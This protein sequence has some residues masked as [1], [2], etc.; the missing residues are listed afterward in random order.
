LWPAPPGAL[1]VAAC[2]FGAAA[3][4]YLG[5]RGEV[6]VPFDPSEVSL[7]SVTARGESGVPISPDA[8]PTVRH[9][10]GWGVSQN[11]P[12]LPFKLPH[13][14]YRFE[15]SCYPGRTVD[16][17][18]ITT[19]GLFSSRTD[20]NYE[21]APEI[22]LGRGDRVTVRAVMRNVPSVPS[23]PLPKPDDGWVK[24]FHG[25]DLTGWKTHPEQPGTWRA[26]GKLLVADGD[27]PGHLFSVRDDYK[28][29][30]FR[31]EA[32]VGDQVR[33]AQIVRASFDL[34]HKWEMPPDSYRAPKGLLAPLT[35][36]ALDFNRVGWLWGFPE[37]MRT[38]PQGGGTRWESSSILVNSDHWFTQE[39]VARGPSISLFIDGKHR[40]TYTD[41]SGAARKGH[42]SLG[43]Y[44]GK[45][46]IRK[47]EVKELPPEPAAG[48]GTK[49]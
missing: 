47:I 48:N 2:G 10:Y 21:P 4:E 20:L 22:H 38:V 8:G 6:E 24:L 15:A 1:L 9:G 36:Q 42:L 31:I 45:I 41:D 30:H 35:W 44:K 26:E 18:E 29:F 34:D 43:H 3:A 49:K 39:I 25:T 7:R 32:R 14:T 16:H 5:G 27:R 33:A 13:G 17:W 46:Q 28:D 37:P 19:H 23:A 12:V 40:A 11:K